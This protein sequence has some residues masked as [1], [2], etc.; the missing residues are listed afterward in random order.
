MKIAIGADHR[1]FLFKEMLKK[2]K[3]IANCAIEWIDFG[4][5]TNEP[6]DYPVFVAPVCKAL[7]AQQVQ[8]GILICGSGVGMSIAANR[9]AGIYAA[10][11]WN[12]D[13]ARVSCQDDNANVLVL[14]ADFI[15]ADRVVAIIAAWLCAQF[16]KG[17][18]QHR[19]AMVDA[20]GGV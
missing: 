2:N 10:L 6:S 17:K 16:K 3:H 5:S 13:V 12:E 19:L 4:A 20:F 14:P 15:S 1:G 7:Q 9:F 11:V 8:K 18:Y